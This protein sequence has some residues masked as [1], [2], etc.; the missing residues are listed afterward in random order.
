MSEVKRFVLRLCSAI[1]NGLALYG[2]AV[3]SVHL[4]ESGNEY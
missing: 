1:T 4:L 3:C 2:A